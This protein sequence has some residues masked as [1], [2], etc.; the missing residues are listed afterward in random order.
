MDA[1]ATL[2]RTAEIDMVLPNY[3]VLKVQ[4]IIKL[5]ILYHKIINLVVEA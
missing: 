2:I 4:F 3:R 1:I 5:Y